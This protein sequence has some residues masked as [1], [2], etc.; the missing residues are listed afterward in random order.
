LTHRARDRGVANPSSALISLIDFG[1][2][3]RINACIFRPMHRRRTSPHG[4]ATLHEK[5]RIRV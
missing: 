3:A 2:V 4:S 1:G 5:A